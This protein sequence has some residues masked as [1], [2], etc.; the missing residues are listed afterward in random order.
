MTSTAVVVA[1]AR[2]AAANLR[3][4]SRHGGGTMATVRAEER[5]AHTLRVAL[6][7]LTSAGRRDLAGLIT[8]EDRLAERLAAAKAA[9]MTR[10]EIKVRLNEARRALRRAAGAR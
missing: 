5:H 3:R 9:G 8:E 4:L 2:T 10:C 1:T 7:E 6:A